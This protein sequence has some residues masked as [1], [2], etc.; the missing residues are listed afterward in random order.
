MRCRKISPLHALFLFL[1]TIL[2]TNISCSLPN[3]FAPD[4]VSPGE[5]ETTI[6]EGEPQPEAIPIEG[7]QIP[8]SM[9]IVLD[10]HGNPIPYASLLGGGLSDMNGIVT[11]EEM[12]YEEAW[13]TVQAEGFAPG[14]ATPDGMIFEARLAPYTHSVLIE[15]PEERTLWTGKAD[16]PEILITIPEGAFAD[17][18]VNV[19]LV[20]LNPLHIG[21]LFVA[22][23]GA[24]DLHIQRAF[25]LQASSLEG[26]AAALTSA[27]NLGMRLHDQGL[28]SDTPTLASFSPDQ[29]QWK[30]IPDACSRVD[31]AYIACTLPGPAPLYAIFDAAEPAYLPSLE[32]LSSSQSR[33]AGLMALV[34]SAWTQSLGDDDIGEALDQ[35]LESYSA[36]LR[37]RLA[38]LRAMCAEDPDACGEAFEDDPYINEILQGMAETAKQYAQLFRDEQ[39]KM[40]LLRVGCAAL[41]LGRVQPDGWDAYGCL[42]DA[43]DITAEMIRKSLEEGKCINLPQT[44]HTYQQATLLGVSDW[45]FK[46]GED[47][48]PLS[49]YEDQISGKSA[50]PGEET[51]QEACDRRIHELYAECD[52]WVGTVFVQYF[53]PDVHPAEA[54]VEWTTAVSIPTWTEKHAMQFWRHP[55]SNQF[56]GYNTVSLKFPPVLYAGVHPHDPCPSFIAYYALPSAFEEA[57]TAEEIEADASSPY[58]S[59]LEGPGE[60]RDP[61]LAPSQIKHRL[62]YSGTYEAGSAEIPD[63]QSSDY[64]QIVQHIHHEHIEDR[65]TGTCGVMFSAGVPVF[66]FTSFLD[67]GLYGD[68]PITMKDLVAQALSSNEESIADEIHYDNPNPDTGSYPCTSVY[69]TWR[70][71]HME[72]A[73]P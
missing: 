42:A 8:A 70:L 32:D 16:E 71:F 63:F 22:L 72:T 56:T 23:D 73:N 7:A 38:Q 45:A 3:V 6:A 4:L 35:V 44:L 13:A 65:K 54:M 9:G 43:M 11:S 40:R 67:H 51:I 36:L 33:A 60:T 27:S 12:T 58:P 64:V 61:R 17:L 26:E 14:F 66:N 68:P 15:V 21:P 57:P 37:Q 41:V 24:K 62:E 30:S 25:S 2:I 53:I 29:G 69:V 20:E 5:S 1:L 19:G 34:P 46:P 50:E 59:E 48:R 28:L 31:E 55:D 18:P 47:D 52:L 39:G 10:L 49:E